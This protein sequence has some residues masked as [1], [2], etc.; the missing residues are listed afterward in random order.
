[1]T[2]TFI[3][4]TKFAWNN[5]LSVFGFGNINNYY[6]NFFPW[7]RINFYFVLMAAPRRKQLD[8]RLSPLGSRVRFSVTAC[9]FRGG[10]NGVWVG[11]SRDFSRFLCHK[12]HSNISRHSSY[13]FRV[14]SF[15]FISSQSISQCDGASS[16][17]GQ[18]PWYSQNFKKRGVIASHPSTRLVSDS[19]W[20]YLFVYIDANVLAHCWQ[21]SSPPFLTAI[22]YNCIHNQLEN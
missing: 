20:G 16:V 15:H 10:R 4:R 9:E 17:V 7:K 18:H 11:S 13:S 3:G 1:M 5:T 8:A 19:S 22:D 2:L 6:E 21:T 14:I 12:F